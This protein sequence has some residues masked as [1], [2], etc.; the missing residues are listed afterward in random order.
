MGKP[1]RQDR[2]TL[3]DTVGMPPALASVGEY[4]PVSE[5]SNTAK[6]QI[7]RG[8][9]GRASTAPGKINLKAV[10]EVL[11]S[12]NLDPAEELAKVLTSR[13]PVLDS[14]GNPVFDPKTGE[15]LTRPQLDIDTFVKTN[16]ELL[17]YTRPKLKAI[18]VTMKE[19]ELTDEQ[20]EK[21]I[22]ALVERNA[23]KG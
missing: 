10:A 7:H 12:Y 20:I 19:P 1:F 17:Q 23:K 15:A 13:V 14:K 16:T 22:Q 18:E 2:G 6:P 3:A 8:H 11:A 5:A 4:D 21:R 9:A